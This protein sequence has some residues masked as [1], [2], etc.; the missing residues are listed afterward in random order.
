MPTTAAPK[1]Q[2]AYQAFN[3]EYTLDPAR[4]DSIFFQKIIYVSGTGQDSLKWARSYAQK[5]PASTTPLELEATIFGATGQTDSAIAVVNRLIEIDPTDTRPVLAVTLSLMQ[6]G[7]DSAALQ[8]VPV[9]KKY[10]DANLKNTYTGILIQFADSAAQR[11]ADSTKYTP[12]DD[13]TMA[14]LARATLDVGPPDSTRSA[15]AQYFLAQAGFKGFVAFSTKVRADKS[16]DELKA[17]T[18][19][20]DAYEPHVTAITSN[21]NPGVANYA[22]QVET[23]IQSERKAIGQMQPVFCK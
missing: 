7:H 5:F 16:C 14:L 11:A 13:S 23:A 12:A 3:Q 19:Y 2:C 22:N 4:V 20:L 18:A 15:F 8:F 21:S 9:V 10:G 6:A 1:F 17:Y